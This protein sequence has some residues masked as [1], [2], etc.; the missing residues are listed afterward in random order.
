MKVST[1]AVARKVIASQHL[2]VVEH[3][4]HARGDRIQCV[5]PSGVPITLAIRRI[6]R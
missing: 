1:H 2:K 5:R 3:V 4:V 6:E